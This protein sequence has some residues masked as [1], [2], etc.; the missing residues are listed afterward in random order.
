MSILTD[1]NI[2]YLELP[3]VSL[4]SRDKLIKPLGS[5]VIISANVSGDDLMWHAVWHINNNQLWSSSVQLDFK[6]KQLWRVDLT[7][8]HLQYTDQGVYRLAVTNGH[9]LPVYSSDMELA[10]QGTTIRLFSCQAL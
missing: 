7:I 3:V 1:F 4:L 5:N 9:T 8:P 2:L 6:M 10:A